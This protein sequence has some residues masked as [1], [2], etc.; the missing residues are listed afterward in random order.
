MSKKNVIHESKSSA[1]FLSDNN[2]VNLK[3]SKNFKIKSPYYVSKKNINSQTSK[4]KREHIN[5]LKHNK[6]SETYIKHSKNKNNII[7]KI[8]KNSLPKYTYTYKVPSSNERKINKIHQKEK[9]NKLFP[10][11]SNSFSKN[12]D[13]SNKNTNYNLYS[14]TNSIE[15]RKEW[16]INIKILNANDPN[17][18]TSVD[19]NI[20]SNTYYNNILSRVKTFLPANKSEIKRK[21]KGL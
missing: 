11:S 13:K 2:L 4:K 7:Q 18:N 12:R 3:E 20:N 1:I 14:S 16:H 8:S 15:K 21:K 17:D 10:S 6:L 19:T 5:K 9:G